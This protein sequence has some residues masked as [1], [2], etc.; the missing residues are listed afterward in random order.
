MFDFLKKSTWSFVSVIVRSLSILL[1]NKIFAIQ[2]G[3]SGITLL[4]HFQNLIG[5]ITQVP[6]DGVNRG[7]IKYWSGKE[8]TKEDKH[9]LFM[10]GLIFNLI[11]FFASAVIILFFQEYFF[12]DFDITLS[13]PFFLLLFF[14]GL[15]LFLIHLYLLSVILSF[16]RI[17]AYSIIN[18][19]TAMILLGVIFIFS[20]TSPL[21]HTL[22]AYVFSQALGLIFSL[23]YVFRKKYLKIRKA[24]LPPDGFARLGDFVL[25]AFSVVI[26]GKLTDFIVRDYAIQHF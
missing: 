18:M 16:Q 24:S 14:S 20:E 6:N 13:N 22:L 2:F 11:L 19:I 4:A 9:R 7:I 10:A 1:I 3:T 23:V 15:L 8:L 12:R 17:K 21:L 26:F 5:I 25:M